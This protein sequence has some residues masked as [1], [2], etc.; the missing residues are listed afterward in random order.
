MARS[1]SRKTVLTR[2][3]DTVDE[4][5]Y[6]LDAERR[7]VYYN[8]ALA[9][10]LQVEDGS[11]LGTSSRYSSQP[12]ATLPDLQAVVNGLCPP[13]EVFQGRSVTAPI[14]LQTAA[15]ACESMAQFIP[16]Q[17]QSAVRLVFAIV[18]DE[19]TPSSLAAVP[20]RLHDQ[21]RRLR[22]QLGVTYD[23]GQL[24][25]KSA[26]I[27]R[28]RRQ[29][30]IAATVSSH[31]LLTGPPGSG[32]ERLAK[33]I[34]HRC[35]PDAPLVPLACQ[36]LDD[37]LLH[38][39]IVSLLTGSSD[40]VSDDCLR[41]LLLL[42]VD[43][44]VPQAQAELL[45]ML[46][47]ADTAATGRRWHVISTARSPLVAVEGA[48]DPELAHLLST[49]QIDLPPLSD[50]V[51]DIPLLAYYLVEQYAEREGRQIPDLDDAA[52]ELLVAHSW[53]GNIDEL[54]SVLLG[55]LQTM[56]ANRIRAEDLS[57]HL[58]HGI[59]AALHPVPEEQAV[60][61]PRL[62]AEVETEMIRRALRKADSNKAQAARLLGLSR[63]KLLRRIEQL[64]IDQW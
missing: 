3:F 35:A 43:Q 46:L 5:V 57:R 52:I 15:G 25:G 61:L 42:D 1:I 7:L 51:E 27:R 12:V 33:A 48:V 47:E 29:A 45:R 22:R 13:P 23:M 36:F 49:V 55:A 63:A 38:T 6:A 54:R 41:T 40:E 37:E 39:T 53:P 21:I 64:G 19:D 30:E 31:V 9:S 8:A 62:L 20:D 34:H 50:R 14:V 44:L 59:D 17:Q 32:R 56:T 18:A 28:V 10:R 58:V 16:F 4:C 60:D 11:L 26:A 24:V 2:L